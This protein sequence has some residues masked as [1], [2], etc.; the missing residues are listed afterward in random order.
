MEGETPVVELLF[1]LMMQKAVI[2]TRAT[3]TYLRNNLTNLDT[4]IYTL[5]LDI[6]NFNQYVK[7]NVDGLK[8]RVERKDDLMINLFKA[9]Q[10]TSNREFVIYINKNDIS[11]TKATIYHLTS[12]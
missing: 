10:V 4:Y 11:K 1:K 5:N 2:N 12:L 7:L 3:D 9:Y 8:S 6:E